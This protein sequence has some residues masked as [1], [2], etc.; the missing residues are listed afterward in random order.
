MEPRVVTD[1]DWSQALGFQRRKGSSRVSVNTGELRLQ[2]RE[3]GSP[4]DTFCAPWGLSQPFGNGPQDRRSL[5]VE[6]EDAEVVD[7]MR[8]LDDLVLRR[9]IEEQWLG[10]GYSAE[11][12]AQLYTPLCKLPDETRDTALLRL[13]LDTRRIRPDEIRV[14]TSWDEGERRFGVR[15]GKITDLAP[16]SRVSPVFTVSD[17]VWP[18]WNPPPHTQFG[19]SL[20]VDRL[21]IY[22]EV[23][24]TDD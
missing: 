11:E 1:V 17:C 14:A 23:R 21:F 24:P 5:E 20:N 9:A 7:A 6:I 3:I 15:D 4:A 18:T 2:L 8:R 16:Y 12:V 13:K 22:S 19:I 10:D